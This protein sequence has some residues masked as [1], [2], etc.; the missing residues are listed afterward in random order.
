MRDCPSGT[1]ADRARAVERM[2][3]VKARDQRSNAKK[4]T[5]GG[6]TGEV[7]LNGLLTLPLCADS[8]SD[9]TYIPRASLDELLALGCDLT[10]TPLSSSEE[11]VVAGGTS[12]FCHDVVVMNVK[13]QTAAGIVQLREVECRVMEGAEP[14]FLL[15]N[16]MLVSLGI[17]VN[18]QLEQLAA[19][20]IEGNYDPFEPEHEPEMT[21]DNV[22]GRLDEL[23]FEARD[24]GFEPSLLGQLKA[25]VHDF[26]D[27]FTVG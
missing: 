16:K 2:R 17:D 25:L 10:I 7:Q 23:V 22:R 13:L 21:P 6:S 26:A 12:V 20:L 5:T 4:V 9:H 1:E 3:E 24:N 11:V 8:G 27:V 19:P 18:R 14:E 15:G